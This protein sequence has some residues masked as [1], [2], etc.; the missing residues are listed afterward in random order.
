MVD[1]CNPVMLIF[2]NCPHIQFD[3][4]NHEGR[5]QNYTITV[6]V[7]DKQYSER[8]LIQDGGK[9]SYIHHFYRDQ[10][11]NGCVTFTIFKEGEA[12]PIEQVTYYLK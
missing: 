1:I 11:T 12:T 4:I 3:I 2:A 9:F 7:D 8:V 10:I 6:V 5:E